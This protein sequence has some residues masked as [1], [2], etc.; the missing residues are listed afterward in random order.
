MKPPDFTPSR[1]RDRDDNPPIVSSAEAVTQDSRTLT[2][3]L[4]SRAVVPGSASAKFRR[5]SAGANHPDGRRPH[6]TTRPVA[7]MHPPPVT[8][9]VVVGERLRAALPGGGA[10]ERVRASPDAARSRASRSSTGCVRPI[11]LRF[12]QSGLPAACVMQGARVSS[13]SS[14][15]VASPLPAVLLGVELGKAIGTMVRRQRAERELQINRSKVPRLTYSQVAEAPELPGYR[16][17]AS[18]NSQSSWDR[19]DR[20]RQLASSIDDLQ[21]GGPAQ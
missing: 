1:L 18:R 21:L 3:L 10:T 7:H 16:T 6:R 5:V 4:Y 17:A 12:L 13:S 15:L 9:G 14:K 11:L 19:P 20:G 8:G 2:P